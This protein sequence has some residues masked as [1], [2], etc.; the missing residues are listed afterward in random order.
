MVLA[1]VHA[2]PAVIV[3]QLNRIKISRQVELQT[4]VLI[5]FLYLCL[6]YP[7]PVPGQNVAAHEGEFVLQP[8]EFFLKQEFMGFTLLAVT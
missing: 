8:Q 6:V 4:E 1:A 3:I 5:S 2:Q 7:P